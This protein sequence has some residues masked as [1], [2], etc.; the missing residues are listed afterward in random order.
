MYR[1]YIAGKLSDMPGQYIKNMHQMIIY[2]NKVR[3]AGFAP[4]TP[5]LDILLG[6]V[7]G[8]ISEGEYYK[9]GLAWIGVANAIFV[10]PNS[11]DSKGTEREINKAK[12]LDIPVF[13][14]LQELE[15]WRDKKYG[16]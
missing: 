14:T 11:G 4:F 15:A 7:N 12:S 10:V 1:V 5:C 16:Y 13:Y 8:N 9:I 3:K 2:A 6:L